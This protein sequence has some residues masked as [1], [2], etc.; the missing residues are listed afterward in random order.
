MQLQASNLTLQ[1]AVTTV[2]R[3]NS[4]QRWLATLAEAAWLGDGGT[5]SGTMCF[6]P[7]PFM[8]ISTNNK[9]Y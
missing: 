5:G 1:R 8:K 3:A 7:A 2:Q 6:S 9:N 4:W